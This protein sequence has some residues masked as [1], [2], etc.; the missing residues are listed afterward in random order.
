MWE[1]DA[2]TYFLVV[3]NKFSIKTAKSVQAEIMLRYR[4]F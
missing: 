4:I 2:P 3:D 1:G